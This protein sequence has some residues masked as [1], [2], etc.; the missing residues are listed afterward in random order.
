MRVL[1]T[2]QLADFYGV[3][4]KIISKNYTRNKGKYIKGKHYI[5]LEGKKLTEFREQ[6]SHLQVE[7]FDL[8]T[9]VDGNLYIQNLDVQTP[10]LVNL[11]TTNENNLLTE[12]LTICLPLEIST[13]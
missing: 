11:T 5:L 13:K 3:D 7:N 2:K 12:P 4:Q 10:V 6:I 9:P 8:Q 1:T